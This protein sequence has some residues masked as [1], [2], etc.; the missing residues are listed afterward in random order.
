MSAHDYGYG[1]QTDEEREANDAVYR[2]AL[3]LIHQPLTWQAKRAADRAAAAAR[4]L[5]RYEDRR[6]RGVR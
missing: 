6:R 4:G 3:A 1:P 2:A 5:A